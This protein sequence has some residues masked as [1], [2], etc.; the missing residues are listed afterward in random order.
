MLKATVNPKSLNYS[1]IYPRKS[2]EALMAA[3]ATE[4]KVLEEQI[5]AKTEAS[6]PLGLLGMGLGLGFRG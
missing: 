2:Y 3:K 1:P 4:S 5:L 6:G